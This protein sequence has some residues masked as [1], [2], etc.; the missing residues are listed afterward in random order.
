[1]SSSRMTIQTKVMGALGMMLALTML[2]AWSSYSAVSTIERQVATTSRTLSAA[3]GLSQS[4]RD[5]LNAATE[6][7]SDASSTSHWITLL[8]LTLCLGVGAASAFGVYSATGILRRIARELDDGAEQ[9]ASS[10]QQVSTSS[11][12]LAQGTSQQASSLQETST[13]TEEINSMTRKSAENSKSAADCTAEAN[14]RICQANR[15]LELMMT[16]MGEINASSDKISKIIKVIDEIAFQTNILALNAAVEAARAGE[17]GMGFAVVADEVRN[18]AQRCAQAAKDTSV[19]IE[20]SISKS[21]EGK[22]KL[23][24]VVK[25]IQGVTD[26][27]GK[28]KTLVDEVNVGSQEQARGSDQ[29]AR[30]VVQMEQVTHRTAASAEQGAAAGQQLTAQSATLRELVKQLNALLGWGAGELTTNLASRRVSA[31]APLRPPA[32]PPRGGASPRATKTSSKASSRPAAKAP[33]KT[34]PKPATPAATTPS[35]DWMAAT[36]PSAGKDSFP[37]DKEFSEF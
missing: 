34:E 5:L 3:Q 24:E 26:S 14:D 8:L 18:L 29:I 9:V 15:H 7:A 25:V 33:S 27:V 30:S 10:A 35:D 2:L 20:D 4:D 23:D 6:R 13:T 36:E 28:V 22:V 21:V 19:L 37:M 16:A 11:Q 12:S 17:A 31:T 1:M 32:A